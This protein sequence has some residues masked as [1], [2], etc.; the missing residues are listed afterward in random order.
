MFEIFWRKISNINLQGRINI[1][2]IIYIPDIVKYVDFFK[3]SD[4]VGMIV[5]MRVQ[6]LII[7]YH[8]LF[9]I[10]AIHNMTNSLFENYEAG[11]LFGFV[12]NIQ[13]SEII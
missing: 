4:W 12:H 6:D 1:V 5:E 9:D 11:K 3:G 10:I 2:Y 7:K 13:F 8:D